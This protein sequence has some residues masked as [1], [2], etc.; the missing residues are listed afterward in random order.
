[1]ARVTIGVRLV[2]LLSNRGRKNM[3]VSV[4][5]GHYRF[6]YS[7]LFHYPRY[8][9]DICP[10]KYL[11]RRIFRGHGETGKHSRLKICRR[12]RLLGSSPSVPTMRSLYCPCLYRLGQPFHE[13][14]CTFGLIALPVINGAFIGH[15]RDIFY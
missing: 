11:T 13:H 2:G 4:I 1:M 9:L 12:N 14:F 10:V 6:F 5:L 3:W 15:I 8:R 7:V